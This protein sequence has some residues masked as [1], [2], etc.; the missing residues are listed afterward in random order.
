MQT[1]RMKHFK[2]KHIQTNNTA[3]K[4]KGTYGYIKNRI[5][6]LAKNSKS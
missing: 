3:S 4:V 5:F 6:E 2:F 1:N